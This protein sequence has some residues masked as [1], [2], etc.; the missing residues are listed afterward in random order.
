MAAFC[1]ISRDDRI[2]KILTHPAML[3]LGT[4]TLCLLPLIGPFVSPSHLALYHLEGSSAPL[5]LSILLNVFVLWLMLTGLFILAQR[6]GGPRIFIWSSLALTTPWIL[7]KSYA[8]MAPWLM[9]HGLSVSV[10]AVCMMALISVLFLLWRRP[11]F[12]VQFE[13]TQH[14]IATLLGFVALSG[15]LVLG[16]MLWLAV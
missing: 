16:P 11:A 7:L 12:L 13:R 8:I 1:S 6:P 10:F 9:P 3:A 2:M 14:F 15:L 4:T 5:V